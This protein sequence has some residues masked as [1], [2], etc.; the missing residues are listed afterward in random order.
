MVAVHVP[1]PG[2]S[3]LTRP[4]STTPKPGMRKTKRSGSTTPSRK[5]RAT[6][7]RPRPA[8]KSAATPAP[9]TAPAAPFCVV[10]I[11]ASAGG[12]EATATLLA[13]LPADCGLAIVVVQ[14]LDPT[15]H[16]QAT[17]LLA[18]RTALVVETA[19]D[20]TS[21]EVNHVYTIPSDRDAH[22]EG[23]RLRL[24]RQPGK[25]QVHLPIDRFFRS[26]GEELRERA[27]GVVLSGTGSDGSLGLE[28]I[29]SHGGIVLVQDPAGA[30]YDGM[31]RSAI[32]TGLASRVLPVAEMP[33]FL[34]RYARHPYA[35]GSAGVEPVSAREVAPFEQILAALR[36][37]HLLDFS[38][39]KRSMVMRRIERR[40]GLR[41]IEA[42]ADYADL[43]AKEPGEI[44]ALHRDL[45]I[46]VTGFFRDPQ[47]WQ[48][49]EREAIAPIVAARN[50][51]DPVRVWV[52]GASTGEEA[53][54]IAMVLLE[55]RER[56]GKQCGV[57]VFGTDA[58]EEAIAFARRG[59]YP[60]GIAEHISAERLQRFFERVDGDQH[61][62]VRPDLRACVIF[63][64]QKLIDDPP[65]SRL[66][67]ISCR[68]V[69]MYLEP[70][71]QRQALNSLHYALHPGGFLFLGTAESA[72]L[73]TNDLLPV[74]K[75]W[76][77][78]RRADSTRPTVLPA[79]TGKPIARLRMPIPKLRDAMRPAHALTTMAEHILLEHYCAAAFL[80]DRAGAALYLYGR[81]EP[82]L[83]RRSGPPTQ[84]LLAILRPDLRAPLRRALRQVLQ[85]EAHTAVEEA[86]VRRDHALTSVRMTILPA[87]RPKAPAPLWLVILQDVPLVRAPAKRVRGALAGVVKQLEEELRSTQQDLRNSV[88]QMDASTQ[89]LKS[90][91]EELVTL[92]EELQVANEEL[93][94]SKEELQSLNEELQ[95]V[96][97]QLQSKV[98][99][100]ETSGNDLNNLLESSQIITVCFDR[101]LRVRWFAPTARTAFKM[102]P[103]DIGRA[104][105]TFDDTPIGPTAATDARRVLG[106]TATAVAEVLWNGR[107]YARRILPYRTAR[108]KVDGIIITLTDIT[109]SKAAAEAILAERANQAAALEK[110][111]VDRTVQLRELSVALSLTE[112]RERRAIAADLHD[113][114]GQ[115][116]ALLKMR[117]DLLRNQAPDGP[118]AEDLTAS[119]A[120]LLQASDRVRSLAFQLSPTVLYELGLVPALEWLADEMKRLYS[121]TVTV[122]SD[123][124]MRANL[125]VTT[126]TILFRAVRE[127]LI[128]VG[129]HAHTDI[130]HV[131]CRRTADAVIIVVTDNG[132]GF[133]PA[134][135][136][137]T[138]AGR[139]F[140]LRSI[141]ERLAGIGGTM[142]CES[143]LDDGSRV[144]LR[145]P[146][147]FSAASKKRAV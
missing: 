20:G 104:M 131:D 9:A 28:A 144:T 88:E 1:L 44:D 15:H 137:S 26:L 113:D 39:Y 108:D 116:L 10:G 46:G 127:L 64:V 84:D 56:L 110:G 82:Y 40:M 133:D 100:L 114:L 105:A 32:A 16:S 35:T 92:N 136:L 138:D 52:A 36:T 124:A 86:R 126:R 119:S 51:N 59:R 50:N 90:S 30:L 8:S 14:H 53:Y 135:I 38:I 79:A 111:I 58:S 47:A 142:T 74:S 6:K 123:R 18:R 72:E 147:P 41:Q 125:D 37:S 2:A 69:L 118:L 62:Q 61:F 96:N 109:E 23:G 5:A 77:I 3:T 112:E 48:V 25:P 117:I 60:A 93:Q 70:P 71:A 11:G 143:I 120:L 115:T 29:I 31:P 146:M 13:A 57:Q 73:G 65:F 63:G 55:A 67:L 129:K 43:L 107:W 54:S 121:L 103:N 130:A 34:C 87:T 98:A 122:V 4:G 12:F 94:S 49:L 99:E 68:N 24:L 83:A 141:R 66:D 7:T 21:V 89:D 91:N 134:V 42:L 75:R 139:G 85:Q 101:D 45:L 80:V 22:L 145:V 128:N 140:G 95:T 102:V 106:G 81:T 97:Q 27:I 78:Y 33:E 19:R 132:K 76:R 17:E